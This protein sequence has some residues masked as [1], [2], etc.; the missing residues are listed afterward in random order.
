MQKFLKYTL[1]VCFLIFSQ[2]SSADV[3]KT[4]NNHW[5]N[6]WENKYRNWVAKEWKPDFFMN[7][8]KRPQYY[9]IPHDCADA[10]YLMRAVFSYENKLP[11]KIHYL[12]KKNKYISNTMKNWDKFP[13]SQRFRKFARF[14]N[15]RVGT[16]TFFRDSFPIAL[17]DIKAGDLYAQPGS[18]SY[19]INGVTE[20]GVLAIMSSTT[21]SAPKN[22]IQ[23]YSFP[24]FIPTD[25]VRMTDG[26]RRFM[27]PRNIDKPVQQ[28]PGFS[29]E[30]YQ[31]AQSVGLNYIPF[32]DIIAKKLQRRKE[33]LEEKTMRL[34]HSLC[35]F[36]KE[37]V[38]YVNDGLA[39]LNSLK[40]KGKRRCMNATEYDYY[41]TPSRD[42][43]L[44]RFFQEVYKIAYSGG[45]LTEDEVNAQILARTIFH[46]ELPDGL[47][48][49][50]DDFCGLPIY[51]G[52]NTKHINLRQL[53]K[54][55]DAR[56]LSSDPHAPFVNRWG[57]TAKKYVGSCKTF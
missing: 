12:A 35:S 30:Q 5:N 57:L 23:L 17:A 48:K 6:N 33:P 10:I 43:R 11:F 27:W 26:Y 38:N 56:K 1:I 8:K 52:N 15:D 22:M 19:A 39:Y 53:W 14:M 47:L 20:T 40:K 51:P 2:T 21:P 7:T 41:S 24:F 54:S 9:R 16:R 42:K 46:P 50:L 49:E 25:T 18:H 45:K 37:R 29:S 44:Y 36:A 28:Q 3:W 4:G 13:Q 34:M 55:M 31:I 32:T